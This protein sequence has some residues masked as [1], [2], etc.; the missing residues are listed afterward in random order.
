LHV[1]WAWTRG[2]VQYR[3]VFDNHMPLFQM[4][5]APLLGVMGEHA[6]DLFWMRGLMLPLY[7]VSLWTT[8]RIGE[9][10][11]S[12]RVGIWSAVLL[13]CYSNY[14]LCSTEFRTDN[15]WAPLWLLSLLVLISGTF[16][17]R[18]A[19][20]SGLLLG[21]CFGV[22]MKTTLMLL[23]IVTAAVMAASLIGWS[24][25][26]L[27]WS[28]VAKS[29][30][31]FL[32]A[33][34]TVPVSIF[35]FFAANGIWSQMH[36]CVF[37]HNLIHHTASTRSYLHL[38]I[39]PV[40]LPLLIY[41]LRKVFWNQLRSPKAFCA[42]FLCFVGCAYFLILESLWGHITRQDFLPFY[43]VA[44]L[45]A[46]AG[47][48]AV[49][50]FRVPLPA[51]AAVLMVTCSLLQHLPRTNAAAHEVDLVRE[52]LQITRPD[53]YVFDRK[54]ETVFRRR[55]FYYVLEGLTRERLRR[56]LI[57]DDIEQRCIETHTC[58]AVTGAHIPARAQ[59]FIEAN[60]LRGPGRVRVA[61]Y[62]L[63]P[64]PGDKEMEFTV[65]IPADYVLIAPE[66]DVSGLLDGAPYEHAR[67]LEAG[68]HHFRLTSPAQ[69]LALV[70]A[71]AV[72]QNFSPFA[73]HHGLPKTRT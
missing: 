4:L 42:L 51:F 43:P 23:T 45:V 31:A 14:H 3:D 60:Y 58:V 59:H 17:V 18:R 71:P 50:S 55:A 21:L 73:R 70:W 49:P 15:L 54:G 63:H 10:V 19:L 69:R 66:G 39:L 25:L 57:T 27:N 29:S 53:D 40:A 20:V 67:F 35:V 46:V 22:S 64:S 2:L 68:K 72:E 47:L 38:L 7:F 34:A 32:G 33:T 61:G 11:F 41:G 48:C 28:E 44:A 6:Q 8:Y 24:K 52:V 16:S 26:D 12:R 37:E 56:H 62:F 30:A 36:Y 5:C 13:A 65:A 1:V 9:K